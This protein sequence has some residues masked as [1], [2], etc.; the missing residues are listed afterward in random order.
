MNYCTVIF[1]DSS[2][3]KSSTGVQSKFLWAW[4]KREVDVAKGSGENEWME[5][6]QG[7]WKLDWLLSTGCVYPIQNQTEY[8]SEIEEG[9]KALAALTEHKKIY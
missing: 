2:L 5:N 6:P 3:I 1:L 9:Q 7:V 8:G 4:Y